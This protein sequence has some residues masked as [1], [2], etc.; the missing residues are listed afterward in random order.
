MSVSREEHRRWL[1]EG[2]M[3]E[4]EGRELAG[5]C[6]LR[7]VVVL[8]LTGVS[9]AFADSAVAG[10]DAAT[11]FSS[12]VTVLADAGAGGEELKSERR[13]HTG[14]GRMARLARV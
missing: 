12:R 13:Q 11:A 1:G 9:A 5:Y 7:D 8:V 2:W 4:G 10:E 6:E 14:G 3:R